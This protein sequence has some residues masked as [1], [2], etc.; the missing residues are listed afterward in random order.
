MPP[1]VLQRR[2]DEFDDL[3][4]DCGVSAEHRSLPLLILGRTSHRRSS[5]GR[6]GRIIGGQPAK[7]AQFPWQAHIRIGQY[8]CGGVLGIFSLQYFLS[9]QNNF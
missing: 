8:Q 5:R 3:D 9:P 6:T 2:A 4:S 1:A 7:F